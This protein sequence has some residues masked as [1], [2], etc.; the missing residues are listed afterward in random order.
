MFLKFLLCVAD[1]CLSSHGVCYV[2]PQEETAS[3]I[4]N[5]NNY[6]IGTRLNIAFG[7]ILVFMM[8]S[9]VISLYSV[10]QMNKSARSMSVNT[11]H[12]EYVNNVRNS[13]QKANTAIMTIAL[14]NDETTRATQKSILETARKEYQASISMLDRSKQTSSLNGLITELKNKIQVN[15]KENDKV[16]KLIESDLAELALSSF[17]GNMKTTNAVL[18]LCDRI[19]G[20]QKKESES[21]AS[22]VDGTYR[23]T[24]IIVAATSGVIILLA[25]F[26]ALLLKQ[27]ILKPLNKGVEM[28]RLL[29]TGNLIVDAEISGKDEIS[30]LVKSI[31]DIT[32]ALREIVGGIKIASDNLAS[33]SVQLSSSS[34]EMSQN[35]Q[36]ESSRATQVATASEEMTQTVMEIAKNAVIISKSSSDTAGQARTG[37]EMVE[38]T[39][40]EINVIASTAGEF[41]R[42]INSLSESSKQ[43]GNIIGVISD[44]ADQTNLLALNAAIEAARAGEHGRGFA[45][46]A[47]EVRKLAE[48]TTN[49]TKEIDKSIGSIRGEVGKAI[50][51]MDQT[52]S[53]V[54]S[55]VAR[56]TESGSGLNAIISSVTQLQSMILQIASATEQMHATTEGIAQDIEYIAG[57]TRENSSAAEQITQSSTEMSQLAVNLKQ[58]VDRFVL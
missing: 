12:T 56:A 48:Q 9:G 36:E 55:G 4:I 30:I 32:I 7:S 17:M 28:A 35:I 44:I 31:R 46:V 18:D 38:N 45:V 19:V 47:D 15:A 11:S 43:I 22:A 29:A 21:A 41:S 57:T 25:L 52:T 50:T 53:Q 33:A 27:S 24:N 39:I 37:G 10:W 20:L 14:V 2:Q 1:K 5:N 13:I 6:R 16:I 49:A 51:A 34:Y 3:M 54:E 42:I 23:L 58:I 26:I 40:K 8:L